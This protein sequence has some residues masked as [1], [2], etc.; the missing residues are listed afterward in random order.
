MGELFPRQGKF[1]A[2]RRLLCTCWTPMS[3]VEEMVPSG[4]AGCCN[5][6]ERECGC[7]RARL[8]VLRS[9]FSPRRASRGPRVRWGGL[10]ETEHSGNLGQEDCFSELF[11]LKKCQFSI[12]VQCVELFLPPTLQI[13]FKT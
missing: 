9:L 2:A 4:E 13:V 8:G 11:F 10:A 7:H 3:T 12:I 5:P 1:W 6:Q